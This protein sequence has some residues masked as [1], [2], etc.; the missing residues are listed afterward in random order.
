MSKEAGRIRRVIGR[1]TSRE[2]IAEILKMAQVEATI[3]VFSDDGQRLDRAVEIYEAAK[4]ALGIA[5]VRLQ[6]P[7][8]TAAA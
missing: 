3:A 2:D 8:Y 5:S 7:R 6:A 1:L 4:E